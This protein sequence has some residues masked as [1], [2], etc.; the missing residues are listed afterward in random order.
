[1][2]LSKYVMRMVEFHG[3]NLVTSISIGDKRAWNNTINLYRAIVIR[4]R[5]FM[6]SYKMTVY[7]KILLLTSNLF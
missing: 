6:F 4:M 7:Y 1:M 5:I 3:K 2:V